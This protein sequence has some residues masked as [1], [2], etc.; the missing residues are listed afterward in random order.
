MTF[1]RRGFLAFLGAAAGSAVVAPLLARFTSDTE[2]VEF[3]RIEMQDLNAVFQEVYGKARL[4]DLIYKE[5]PF[6]KLLER[7]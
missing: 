4:E 6:L 5:N 3:T 2:V 1:T 7:K